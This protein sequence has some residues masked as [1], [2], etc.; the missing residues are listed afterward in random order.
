MPTFLTTPRMSPALRARIERSLSQRAKAK[1]SA[2]ATG[3]G[4]AF[5]GPSPRRVSV[6]RLIPIVAIGIV[7]LLFGLARRSDARELEEARAEILATLEAQR[8]SLPRQ[9]GRFLEL[10]QKRIAEE[11]S[12]PYLGDTV[13][14]ELLVP[15]ELDSWLS[16]PA[17][18]IRGA[19]PEL[20]DPGKLGE[21]AATSIKDAFLMC[22]IEP[23]A[24]HAERDVLAKI[25]GVYFAGAK[26]DDE[27]A[28]IRRLL[29]AQ[30]GLAVF[31]R[32][33]EA[34]A[35]AA[36]DLSVLKRL[37]RDLDSAPID[38]ARLASSA[39]LLIVVADEIQEPDPAR[40]PAQTADSLGYRAQESAHDARVAL[41]DL[42]S[43]TVLLRVRRRLDASSRSDRATA[44]YRVAIQ[45]C[46]LALDVR[47]AT[48][49]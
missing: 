14:P 16:R 26:V 49:N 47:S 30:Q 38:A 6:G 9:S 11:T 36:E 42:A 5:K 4:G 29:E 2:R 31:N 48:E 46:D 41:I 8:G 13:A 34:D 17:V 1:H 10:T 37:R 24:S 28:N 32:T 35:R 15:G 20:R 18:Y 45:G 39:E 22:L 27:T 25:R 7:A 19:T 43:G 33:F 44:L 21:A 40:K 3:L 23:A 12:G